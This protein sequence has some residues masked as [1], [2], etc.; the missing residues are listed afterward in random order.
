MSH[1]PTHNLMRNNSFPCD[2]CVM[3]AVSCTS[4]AFL[5]T[6]GLISVTLTETQIIGLR[7]WS[8]TISADLHGCHPS[9]LL[10]KVFGTASSSLHGHVQD[11]LGNEPLP[12][13]RFIWTGTIR[14][15][16]INTAN[17]P[18]HFVPGIR[19]A[20]SIHW[21]FLWGLRESVQQNTESIL[22]S[23]GHCKSVEWDNFLIATCLINPDFVSHK[24]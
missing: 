4:L 18:V 1:K 9:Q 10:W 8:I 21:S 5:R 12:R 11:L 20:K 14:M 23:T 7:G 6:S 15:M 3:N 13:I 24:S 19:I 16:M 17:P 2:C 22:G